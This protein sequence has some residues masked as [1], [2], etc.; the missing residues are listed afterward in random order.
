MDEGQ[1]VGYTAISVRAA[2][3]KGYCYGYGLN[4]KCLPQAHVF[5]PLIPSWCCLFLEATE[6]FRR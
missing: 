2:N 5:E 4:L 1:R 3:G 6:P